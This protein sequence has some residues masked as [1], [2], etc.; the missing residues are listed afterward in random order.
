MTHETPPL[1]TLRQALSALI[2]AGALVGASAQSTYT[3]DEMLVKTPSDERAPGKAGAA[4]APAIV[5]IPSGPSGLDCS[6]AALRQAV[7]A[8]ARR[9]SPEE[10][11]EGGALPARGGRSAHRDNS[12]R[13]VLSLLVFGDAE[14]AQASAAC[15][16]FVELE[17]RAAATGKTAGTD[18]AAPPRR[19]G[20]WC[21]KKHC[22]CWKGNLYDGCV[23]TEKLC[24]GDL[25]CTGRICHCHA[26]GD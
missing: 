3:P 12:G 18:L 9:T 11:D 22:L 25:V 1:Q 13:P 19:E 21:G 17:R 10:G 8:G 4:R 14:A 5:T 2:L 7:E 23:H 16:R 15:R 20:I 26:K 6:P 24:A